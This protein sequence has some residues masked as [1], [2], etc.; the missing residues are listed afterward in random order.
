MRLEH[1]YYIL[2][3][4]KCRSI[5]KASANLYMTQQQL[6]RHIRSAEKEIGFNIFDRNNFGITV[7]P[8][9]EIALSKIKKILNLYNEF[10][11]SPLPSKNDFSESIRGHL[12]LFTSFNIFNGYSNLLSE[13]TSLYPEVDVTMS[14]LNDLEIIN[15][16]TSHKES[17]GLIKQLTF[18]DQT[19]YAIPNELNFFTPVVGHLVVY[20]SIDH[21][22]VT[23][24]KSIS[25]KTL[26]KLPLIV[27]ESDILLDLLNQYYK[28]N[29][30]YI[31][32]EAH[33]YRKILS[34]GN[35]IALGFNKPIYIRMDNIVAIPLKEKIRYCCGILSNKTN[36][37]SVVNEAFFKFYDSYSAN[38]F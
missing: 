28:L 12:S 27:Y 30:K 9:G 8:K 19:I 20:A 17:I 15:H 36:T 16:L 4:A 23:K 25:L 11:D 22:I 35:C 31:V 5:S 21:P 1:L 26:S 32:G 6:S 18:E 2:E 10:S 13:F 3:V 24:Y 7:T 34:Q 14:T 29:V 38:L 33:S 37:P